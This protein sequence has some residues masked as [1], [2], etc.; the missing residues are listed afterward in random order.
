[1]IHLKYIIAILLLSLSVGGYAK[2]WVT[3]NSA[4]GQ[5]EEPIVQ[6]VTSDSQQYTFKVK[7]PGYWR[8][9]ETKSG[10]IFYSLELNENQTLTKIGEPALPTISML[11]GLPS[12]T[13]ARCY[14]VGQVW[15]ED[16]YLST[17][18]VVPYQKP[19]LET[20]TSGVLEINQ[21]VYSLPQYNSEL[22]SL[23]GLMCWN[24][25][26]NVNLTICPFIYRPV[27]NVISALKE[28]TVRV[29][30]A[31]DPSAVDTDSDPLRSE[32]MLMTGISN[33]NNALAETYQSVS[34]ISSLTTYPSDLYDYLI[35]TAPNYN[36]SLA[37]LDFCKWKSQKGYKCKMVSTS[38]TG[39]TTS[40]I[41]NYISNEYKKGIRYVLFVGDHENIPVYYW[42]YTDSN[43]KKENSKSDYWYGCMDG[44][45][46]IQADVAIGRFCVSSSTELNR[47]VNKTINYEKNPPKDSWVRKNLL[48][49][50]REM[51]PGKYQGCLE[52][53]R[54]TDYL[55]DLPDFIKIYGATTDKGG[56]NATNATIINQ[57]NSGAGIVNYRGHG[58]Q[59]E[60]A[61]GWCSDASGYGESYVNQLTNTL[62]TPVVFSIAC[63]NGDITYSSKCLL[64]MFTRNSVGAVAFLGATEPSYTV[65]NHTYDKYIYSTIFN[66]G[67]C[68]IGQIN[69]M[70]QVRTLNYYSNSG[71]ALA[72]AFA[73]LWG[74]DPS[75]ELWTDDISEFSTVSVIKQGNT[76]HVNTNGLSDCKI[77][78]YS[79]SDNGNS[80]FSCVE[81]VSSAQFSR[82]TV[83]C[84]VSVNKHNYIPYV[85]YV[86]SQDLFIQNETITGTRKECARNIFVGSDVTSSKSAGKVVVQ[87]SADVELKVSNK[88][89]IKN[90][91]LLK[92]GAKLKIG[93]K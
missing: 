71:Q 11:V 40:S 64:E 25:M 33:Y 86:N 7:I 93:N 35:I 83:P 24:G 16:M 6:Q 88:V 70:A 90:G 31:Q 18:K 36:K 39:I 55:L 68:N 50:H 44:S 76:V 30:F 2:E 4:L 58:S 84:Y 5:S 79:A 32:K 80:Y 91:F 17:Y 89:V 69:N 82:V 20:E 15:A 38:Q 13:I 78:I 87:P 22:V 10:S 26:K 67:I 1:M 62:K 59:Y 73:Y 51:A 14:I 72:N 29:E 63:D 85:V 60:W 65:V 43:R 34:A 23:S 53:I 37:L 28:I 57:I 45:D 52:E 42:T 54:T 9:L 66:D 48:I 77:T 21:Q 46:D 3:V 47:M 75:L 92:K 19:L 27:T 41:K 61:R 56:N 81:G 12:G 49:A 74:G 8:T